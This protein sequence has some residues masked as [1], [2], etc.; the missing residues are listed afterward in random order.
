MI[1]SELIK[2]LLLSI[3]DSGDKSPLF[4]Q[5]YE[6][7]IR[8]SIATLNLGKNQMIR[9]DLQRKM[10]CSAQDLACDC[11]WKLFI[12]KQGRLIEFEKYFNKHF[13]DGIG[14]IYPDRIK[15][16]LA[17]LIKA[18]TNQGLSLIREEW[19]DIF[20]DIRKAVSTEIARRK[21]IYV[22]HYVHG[23]K[24]I[25]F[26]HKE[27]ID[28]SLPQVEKDYLLGMLFLVKLK[29]YDY[30]KVLRTVFEILSTQQEYCKAV[31]EKLLLDILKE[32]Y[33]TKA[34][35]FIELNNSVENSNVEYIV[36]EDNFEH[37]N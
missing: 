31:E 22:K 30:T 24:F 10:D 3:L 14:T 12:P 9:N 33:Y 8:F 34:S 2:K 26:D 35:D 7:C 37:D 20:F 23:V 21:K 5:F 1:D 6:I 28:F 36:D 32:F 17:I 15:A 4:S 19:G 27:Q 16:Q 25:S 29:K 13:P 18:R 11:I